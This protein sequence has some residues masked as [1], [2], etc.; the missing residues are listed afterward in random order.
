MITRN[1]LFY[2]WLWSDVYCFKE[3]MLVYCLM[4]IYWYL[5]V[6]CWYL[7]GIDYYGNDI[8]S[9]PSHVNYSKGAGRQDCIWKCRRLCQLTAKCQF[10]TYHLSGG[11]CWLKTSSSGRRKV[12]RGSGIISG[13][14]NCRGGMNI[15][16]PYF[17]EKWY[18][19]GFLT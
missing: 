7:R 19:T 5:S 6:Q 18:I 1:I 17:K 4:I 2:D 14:R 13:S 12:D 15:H 16:S 3:L 10:F 11:Y 8:N 9:D